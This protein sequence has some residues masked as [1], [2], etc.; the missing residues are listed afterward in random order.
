MKIKEGFLLRQ[1]AGRIVV[2][3]SEETLD[4]NV[5]ITLN[6]TGRYLWERLEQGAT[7]EELIGA[8]MQTYQVSEELARR[9][10]DLFV[11]KLAVNNFLE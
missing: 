1:I 7:R 6:S 5:M 8:L 4:L 10:V 9:D 11:E 3:P 2:I